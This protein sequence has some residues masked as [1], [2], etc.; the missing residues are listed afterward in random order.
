[1][2]IGAIIKVVE[3]ALLMSIFFAKINVVVNARTSLR[4]LM[5]ASVTENHCGAYRELACIL[6]LY[7][8]LERKSASAFG[9]KIV[10]ILPFWLRRWRGRFFAFSDQLHFESEVSSQLSKA[11]ESASTRNIETLAA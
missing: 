8:T 7:G 2:Q 11:L 10:Q 6:N 3:T 9:G 4:G 5:T 1:M